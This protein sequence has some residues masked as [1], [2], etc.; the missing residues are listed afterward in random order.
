MEK[1]VVKPAIKVNNAKLLTVEKKKAQPTQKNSTSKSGVEIFE[2]VK[3]QIEE[4]KSP[5]DFI[6][7]FCKKL[8]VPPSQ[9]WNK[10]HYW[11]TTIKNHTVSL[12]SVKERVMLNNVMSYEH[13]VIV[14]IN[15]Q[16]YLIDAVKIAEMIITLE[17]LN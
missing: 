13:Y 5:I 3:S 6:E 2:S 4:Q 7:H 12:Y 8:D 1:A 11:T 9:F 17:E 15:G 10:N 14:E 16:T